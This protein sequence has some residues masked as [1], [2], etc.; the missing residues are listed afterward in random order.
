MDL[1]VS[2]HFGAMMG[3]FHSRSSIWQSEEASPL[4]PQVQDQTWMY[5][6][7]QDIMCIHCEK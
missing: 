2:S 6:E 4:C 5:K 1:D 7:A 3:R